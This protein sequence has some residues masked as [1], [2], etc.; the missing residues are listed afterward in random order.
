M[1]CIR[2]SGVSALKET[3]ME[4][5]A[6]FAASADCMLV[7]AMTEKAPTKRESVR[8]TMAAKVSQPF[9]MKYWQPS[10]IICCGECTVQFASLQ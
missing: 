5:L 6:F 1:L 4:R 8:M 2:S 10:P 9:L 7:A 3:A